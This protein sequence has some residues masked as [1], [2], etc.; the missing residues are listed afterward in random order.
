M[1]TLTIDKAGRV[2]IPKVLRERLHLR[3]GDILE[4]VSD[5]EQIALR[6]VRA[7]GRMTKELGMWVFS[8][9]GEPISAET[10]DA[11]LEDLRRERDEHNMGV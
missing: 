11:V 3:P 9:D 1:E 5:E 6:P 7:T 10:T 4:V 2:V 8:A